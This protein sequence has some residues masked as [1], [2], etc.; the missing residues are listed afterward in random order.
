MEGSGTSVEI[1]KELGI[2]AYGL[3][4]KDGF[5]ILK[6]TI[7]GRIGKEVD[8]CVSHPPY[9]DM[10]VYSGKVWGDSPVEGDLSRCRDIEE[11]YEKMTMA[12]VNQRQAVKGGGWYGTIVGDLRRQGQYYSIQAEIQARMDRTEY[13]ATLIKE[14]HNV[15]SGGKEYAGLRMPRIMHE[16]I[17]LWQKKEP[18]MMIRVVEQNER[19]LKDTW[20]VIVKYALM[21]LRG[22]G[23]LKDIYSVVERSAP[24]K[25]KGNPHWE[26]KVRQVVQKSNAIERTGKGK[27]RIKK[28]EGFS[29]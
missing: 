23:E 15:F 12:L 24:E 14:Q 9:H 28:E 6:E 13:K 8:V 18:G 22:E 20:N 16:Y 11:F 10:I 21:T 19:R 25:V 27:Y 4:L 5:N 26:E 29:Y 7:L 17:L 2:E 1:A 3:D